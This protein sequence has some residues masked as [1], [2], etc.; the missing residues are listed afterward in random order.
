MSICIELDGPPQAN[1][2]E[3]G[4]RT[5]DS[6]YFTK[7]AQLVGFDVSPAGDRT[8]PDIQHAAPEGDH[9]ESTRRKR[10]RVGTA[11]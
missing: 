1:F 6:T 2:R 8:S 5:L 11:V 10:Q 3:L 9:E 4:A 7:Y